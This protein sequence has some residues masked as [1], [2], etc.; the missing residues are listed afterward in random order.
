MLLNSVLR[1]FESYLTRLHLLKFIKI[2]VKKSISNIILSEGQ[3]CLLLVDKKHN[4]GFCRM[5]K[6]ASSSWLMRFQLLRSENDESAKEK[7]VDKVGKWNIWD[8]AKLHANA[9][10]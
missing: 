10:K 1:R 8:N 2:I 4:L 7:M 3:N 5:P 6:V 9:Q